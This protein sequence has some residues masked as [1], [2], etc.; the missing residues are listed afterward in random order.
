MNSQG[1]RLWDDLD[2]WL[3]VAGR[4]QVRTVDEVIP[5]MPGSCLILRGG[6]GY[7]FEQ[8]AGRRF[9]HY[10]VHYNYVDSHDE[11][12]PHAKLDLPPM[13][14]QLNDWSLLEQLLDR[15]LETHAGNDHVRVDRWF[16]AVLAE[17]ARQDRCMGYDGDAKSTQIREL[18]DQIRSEP[19]LDWIVAEMADNAGFDPSY[20]SRQF[21]IQTGLSPR[22]YVT[23][24]RMSKA[25]FLLRASNQ[26]IGTIA[27]LLG[28]R[29]VP[30]FCRHFRRNTGQSP[31]AYRKGTHTG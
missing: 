29:D 18:C 27:S 11:I 21:R 30:F 12:I 22:Q 9:I 3:L 16:Q 4:G 24:V 31:S 28:Y 14:R 6:Q 5:L 15:M 20:F 23:H 13:S 1:T 26:S 19:G 10:W 25:C 17:V 2:L 7:D 8:F